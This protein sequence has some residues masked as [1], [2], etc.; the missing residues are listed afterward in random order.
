MA[1]EM[2]HTQTVQAEM[3][4]VIEDALNQRW[5]ADSAVVSKGEVPGIIEVS[6]MVDWVLFTVKV[7]A[8][9]K[10]GTRPACWPTR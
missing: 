7:Q 9:G 5:G 1:R 6:G 10:R 2:T 3:A 4:R 8:W